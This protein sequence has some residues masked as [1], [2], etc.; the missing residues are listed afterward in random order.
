LV[1]G[2]VENKSLYMQG[3]FSD[4]IDTLG[5]QAQQILKT[6]LSSTG[7]FILMDRANMEMLANEAGYSGTKPQITAAEVV[8]TGAVTEFGRREVGNE[9]LAGLVATSK[10]QVAYAKVAMSVVDVRTSQVLFSAQGAGEYDLS[11]QQVMGFGGTASYDATLNDKVL[12]LAM[13]EVVQ[14]LV[15]GLDQGK[16][17]KP[18]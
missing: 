14:R 8:L 5:L 10:K 15:D 18:E 4:G 13:M 6:H 12:N 16:W 3:I 17:G 1:I 11:N 9:A 7:R 2:K